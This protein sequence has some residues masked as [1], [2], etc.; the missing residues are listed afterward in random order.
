MFTSHEKGVLGEL[1]FTIHLIQRGYTILNPLNPNS[2]YDL[3][4]EKNGNFMRI[5]VKYCTPRN[6]RIRVELERPKRKTKNY[7]DRNVDAMG[8]YDSQSEKCYLIPISQI[9]EKSEIWLRVD[10]PKNSQQKK[11]NYA[12]KYEI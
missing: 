10:N 8:A 3:V 6:G 7:R 9:N 12:S 2:S 1:A 4:A 11:I 5:Q